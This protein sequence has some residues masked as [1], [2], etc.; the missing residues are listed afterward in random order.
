MNDSVVGLP[1]ANGDTV[2]LHLVD[3]H[4]D[5]TDLLVDIDRDL[6]P[7]HTDTVHSHLFY[8]PLRM[9][10]NRRSIIIVSGEARKRSDLIGTVACPKPFD[11]PPAAVYSVNSRSEPMR[12]RRP[13]GLLMD[14]RGSVSEPGSN[15]AH[16]NC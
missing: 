16:V 9:T 15:V 4:A 12:T 13:D 11:F 2:R 10:R 5:I 1:V 8:I 3:S 6:D 7:R 14:S